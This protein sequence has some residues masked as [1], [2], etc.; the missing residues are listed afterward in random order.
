MIDRL[1]DLRRG[2]LNNGAESEVSMSLAELGEQNASMGTSRLLAKVDMI[3]VLHG[4]SA[5]T[6]M[7]ERSCVC[8][9]GIVLHAVSYE[10]Y[11]VF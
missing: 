7:K 1:S 5:R 8:L 6:L 10:L 3:K 9:R 2:L 11:C 4:L